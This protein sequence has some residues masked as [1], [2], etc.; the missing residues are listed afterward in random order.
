MTETTLDLLVA[1]VPQELQKRRRKEL[2]LLTRSAKAIH[3]H[4]R[5]AKR[6]EAELAKT[7]RNANQMIKE[8]RRGM[9]AQSR[10]L[11]ELHLA[12]GPERRQPQ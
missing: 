6:A 3:R 10:E 8:L 9:A 1:D 11:G 5:R 12:A 4:R 7:K 2:N